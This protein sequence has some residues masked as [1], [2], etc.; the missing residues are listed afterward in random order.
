MTVIRAVS[1]H[2]AHEAAQ[3][4]SKCRLVNG[5]QWLPGVLCCCVWSVWSWVT[6]L[7]NSPGRI[8]VTRNQQAKSSYMKNPLL[9]WWH[10][11]L[12]SPPCR[13]SAPPRASSG[14][15]DLLLLREVTPLLLLLFVTHPSQP[16]WHP[17]EMVYC[18]VVIHSSTCVIL[19]CTTRIFWHL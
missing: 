17:E 4:S 1:R 2:A 19:K 15:R 16:F 9:W 13:S 7:T 5:S 18:Q 8:N 14:W 12:S 6:L 3:R 10:W 11:L